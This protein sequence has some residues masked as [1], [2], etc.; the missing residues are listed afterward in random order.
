LTL[1]LLLRK[2]PWGRIAFLW[3]DL[4]MKR[5]DALAI[6]KAH[7]PELRELGVVHLSL[8][9]STAR[10]EARNNSDIDVAVRLEEIASGF[11]TLGRLDLI[12]LRLGQLLE[13]RVDV[14]PEP[15]QPDSLKTAIDRDRCLV[16]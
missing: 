5:D 14:I 8:F 13:A 6:L 11:A 7:A 3:Y 4:Q 15:T 2:A 12:K 16:F 10:D 9:G 1:P